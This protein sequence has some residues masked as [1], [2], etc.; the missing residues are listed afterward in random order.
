MSLSLSSD[1]SP[2]APIVRD[3]R[4]QSPGL[5]SIYL[6]GEDKLT[7]NVPATTESTI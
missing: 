3:N 5:I 7:K 1:G 2:E 4:H 6:A